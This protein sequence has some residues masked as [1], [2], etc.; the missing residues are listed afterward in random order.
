MVSAEDAV[1]RL[2]HGNRRFV[3]S[4]H[5]GE[6]GAGTRRMVLALE[7][8]PFA[9]VLGCS[10]SRVPAEIVFDQG[11][12][13]LF[14]IRVAGN[15]VA[16]S[17]VGSVEFAASRFGTRLVVVLGHSHCGA[18]EATI[19]ELE[20]PSA[21]QSKNLRSIVERVRPSVEPLLGTDLALDRAA[22]S[23]QAMRAN[24]AASVSHLRHG[25]EILEQ[26]IR[27]DGLLV[28]GAEYS[29]ETGVVEFLDGPAAS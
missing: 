9:I 19:E 23:R 29:L 27:T 13:E 7:Q 5:G 11:L 21:S 4:L 18:I 2:K 28:V 24:V 14:V 1:A 16:P 26:L 22:L 15:I 3:Q 10:D 12:G 8:E 20:R 25:S 6:L 17:Q